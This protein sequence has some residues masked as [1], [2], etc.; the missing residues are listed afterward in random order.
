MELRKPTDFD[1]LNLMRGEERFTPKLTSLLI[2]DLTKKYSSERLRHLYREDLV[3]DPANCDYDL[4]DTSNMYRI[5]TLGEIVHE[6]G[7]IY[8][9]DYAPVFEKESKRLENAQSGDVDPALSVVTDRHLHDLETVSGIGRAVPG[10][11][12]HSQEEKMGPDSPPGNSLYALY[13]QGLV[14]RVGNMD[15]YELSQT[16]R[17]VLEEWRETGDVDLDGVRLVD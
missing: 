9:R 7:F 14:D 16:G 17:Q 3:C 11:I 10:E 2:E 1:I 4:N 13:F 15:V 6:H 5:T 12:P 8:D